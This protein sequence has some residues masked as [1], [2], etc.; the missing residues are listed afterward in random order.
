MT[1]M[2]AEM[3]AISSVMSRGG[4]ALGADAARGVPFS[5][6]LRCSSKILLADL[7]TDS[8]SRWLTGAAAAMLTRAASAMNFLRSSRRRWRAL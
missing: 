8:A 4:W 7:R 6:F 1:G 2:A 3:D 5:D